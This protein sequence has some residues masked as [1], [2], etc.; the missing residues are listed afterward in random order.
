[1]SH[2]NTLSVHCNGINNGIPPPPKPQPQLP[3][4]HSPLNNNKYKRKKIKI[5]S[6][7]HRD[8][9]KNKKSVDKNS[10][11]DSDSELQKK[12][13]IGDKIKNISVRL[14]GDPN[15]LYKYWKRTSSKSKYKPH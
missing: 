3:Q 8:K 4:P 13:K 2:I 14:P 12:D 9:K 15:G 1:M 5:K 10:H 6:R 11:C 7:R